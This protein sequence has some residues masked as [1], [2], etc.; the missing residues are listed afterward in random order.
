MSIYL[1][2]QAIAKGK[3]KLPDGILNPYGDLALPEY[4]SANAS[5]DGHL[6]DF[7]DSRFFSFAHDPVL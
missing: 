3:N 1:F 4:P 7:L 6:L 5:A 2:R